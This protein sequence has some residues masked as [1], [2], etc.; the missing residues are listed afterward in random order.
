MPDASPDPAPDALPGA[1]ALAAFRARYEGLSAAAAVQ[2][3]LPEAAGSGDTARVHIGR[4]RKQ[5]LEAARLRRRQ[6]LA[7]LF[8]RLPGPGGPTGAQVAHAIEQL[9]QSPPLKASAHDP[10]EMWLPPAQARVLHSA[11][12]HTLADLAVR[13]AARKR[14][15]AQVPRLGPAGAR[16]IQDLLAGDAHLLRSAREL[17]QHSRSEVVPWEAI[18][19]PHTLD[20]S[21][22]R[23][24]APS[25]QCAIRASNDYEAIHSWLSLHEAPATTRA[26]RKEAERLLLWAVLECRCPLSSL[27]AEDAVAYRAFLRDPRP[28]ERWI[29]PTAPRGSAA[30]R[31]FKAALSPRSVAYALA[32]LTAMFRWLV[33]Q[34]YLVN[35]P[36]AGL[37]VRGGAKSR[38]VDASRALTQ[39]EW[40]FTRAVAQTLEHGAGW[41]DAAAQRLRFILDFTRITGLRAGELCGV[42]LGMIAPDHD[43]RLWLTLSGKGDK[44]GKVAVPP[45]ALAVL[46]LYLSQRALPTVHAHWNPSTPVIARLQGEG[47]L[48]PSRLWAVVKRFFNY[49][50]KVARTTLPATADRL[51]AVS[52]HWLRHTHASHALAAGVDLASVRDNLR[53]ASIAT[54]SGYL[55]S[56]DVRRADQIASAFKT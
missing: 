31:P 6:D 9:R 40:E 49:A 52:P 46:E 10:V 22:G 39:G 29:G 41:S 3:Y 37:K 48:T 18:E 36:F 12:I 21:S 11:G 13:A 19:L 45:S 50:A 28:A 42:T 27:S 51:Q 20:G 14:W 47:T 35:N 43:G 26:Y 1:N 2:R 32:V 4:V 16:R 55:H 17:A 44:L 5:L 54:T 56:E 30:W 8:A 53:H 24:R 34:R 38:T 7:D 23:Y 33:E 15:W 25:A